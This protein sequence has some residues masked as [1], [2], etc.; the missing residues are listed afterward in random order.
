MNGDGSIVV[1]IKYHRPILAVRAK[2]AI[3]GPFLE[4]RIFRIGGANSE[5]TGLNNFGAV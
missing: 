2:Y 5:N 4:I 1:L 3:S